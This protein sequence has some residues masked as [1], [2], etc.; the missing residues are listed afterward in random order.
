VDAEAV[1][2]R[3]TADGVVRVPGAFSADQAAAIRDTVW[4]FVEGHSEIRSADPSTW[5]TKVQISFK[6]LR[7]RAVFAPLIDNPQVEHALDAIF[8]A[9]GWLPPRTP[10][11]QIMLTMPSSAPWILPSGWH[12]DCG[13]EQPT[14]PVFAV[15]LF[16]F[17]D[18]VEAEGGG[19]LLLSG[20]HRLVERYT[21]T[22]PPGTG[23]NGV[24]WGR[25]MKQDPWLN[26]LRRG[27]TAAEPGRH[28]LDTIHHVE[29]IPLRAI[30]LTGQ[31]G[32]MVITHLHVFHTA[33]PNVSDRPRQMLGAGIGAANA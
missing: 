10:H 19:T 18:D 20:S 23:G 32:D 11:A 33:A 30:E 7:G 6:A 2:D 22:L 25:F 21:K 28:L 9:G 8:G 27:G 5:S 17:F 26:Q 3:F 4:R 14:W 29:G 16:S 24:T 1:R 13:F 12:M 15:R 31:P